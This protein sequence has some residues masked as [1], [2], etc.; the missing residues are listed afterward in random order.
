MY[1]IYMKTQCKL[2]VDNMIGDRQVIS[3]HSE[4]TYQGRHFYRWSEVE[5]NFE[6]KKFLTSVSTFL[7][8]FVFGY[9]W[10]LFRIQIF[11]TFIT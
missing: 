2:A 4:G 5:T 7:W 9:V 11:I 10:I 3:L 8:P 1:Q 6:N